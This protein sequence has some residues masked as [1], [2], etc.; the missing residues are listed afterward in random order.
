M[1]CGSP[2]GL[3]TLSCFFTRDGLIISDRSRISWVPR[4]QTSVNFLFWTNTSYQGAGGYQS[5]NLVNSIFQNLA[6]NTQSLQV[7]LRVS[8]VAGDYPGG[9]WMGSC[10][11]LVYPQ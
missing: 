9:K 1:T 7:M 4:I 6:C 5:T 3:P 11:A 8:N 10:D 2:S